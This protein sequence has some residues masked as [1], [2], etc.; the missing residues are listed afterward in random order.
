MRLE[1]EK[2]DFCGRDFVPVI[3][4]QILSCNVPRS[5]RNVCIIGFT[6]MLGSLL[7][8]IYDP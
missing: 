3:E 6:N 5:V 7:D 1:T 4:R 2:E 8:I